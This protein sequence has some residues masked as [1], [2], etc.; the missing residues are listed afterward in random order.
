MAGGGGMAVMSTIGSILGDIS[1][2]LGAREQGR[3][4]LQQSVEAGIQ[5]NIEK[6][7]GKIAEN[8]LRQQ[9][10][11]TLASNAAASAAS[12]VSGPS[13]AASVV[14]D[15]SQGSLAI[16]RT[17]LTTLLRVGALRRQASALHREGKY[18]IMIG[19]LN[20]AATALG[21]NASTWQGF[22]GGPS[23]NGG[24]G[25]GGSG[26][27]VSSNYSGVMGGGATF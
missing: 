12:G 16:D 11:R 25:K 7:N 14:D 17:H 22:G 4:I 24:V 20:S 8:D 1:G 27:D 13:V 2:H 5:A 18:S 10:L 9:L 23:S 6:L 15:I 3:A 21:G 19:S 26:T